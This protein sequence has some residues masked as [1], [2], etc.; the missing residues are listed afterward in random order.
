LSDLEPA[1]SASTAEAS[2]PGLDKVKSLLQD[3]KYSEALSSLQSLPSATKNS[4]SGQMLLCR[5]QEGLQQYDAAIIACDAASKLQPSDPAPLGL[6]GYLYLMAGDY[7]NAATSLE[8]ADKLAS[9]GTY[10]ALLSLAYYRTGQYSQITKL[11][12]A[13]STNKLELS[14]LAGAQWHTSQ[15]DEF[16][17]TYEHLVALSPENGWKYF[18]NAY[19]E[20]TDLK[21]ED[22]GANFRKCDADKDF[23]DSICAW[24]FINVETK[25][26]QWDLASTD[27][28]EALTHY[29]DDKS[30][31][32][33]AIFVNL[34]RGAKSS[35]AS[36][37]QQLK[38]TGHLDEGT[39]CLYFYAIDQPAIATEHCQSNTRENASSHTAWS[40]AG[41]AAVDNG[42]YI[43]ASNL[44][45]KAYNLFT[46]D[47]A[48]HTASEEIDLMW[49]ALIS[50]YFG[51]DR[52]GA[53]DIYK[54]LKKMYPSFVKLEN[55][56]QL[57]LVWSQRS[58]QLVLEAERDLK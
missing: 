33:E 13:E 34:L 50:H 29:P 44:F 2:D 27:A 11:L 24:G 54:G 4:F 31:L 37:Y 56:K 6:K 15:Y 39:S 57:P 49:G 40:N 18:L 51:G 43:A 3:K 25:F 8:A 55:L 17:K 9:E 38:S 26:G 12:A 1:A 21:F 28:T 19:N 5:V 53:K 48:K 35:A 30:L 52:K 58:Q 42:N 10:R 46:A 36:Y 32:N 16:K 7:R 41:W 47:K 14:M 23:V 20:Y 45:A 22:A